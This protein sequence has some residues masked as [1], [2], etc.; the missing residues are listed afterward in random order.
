VNL[1]DTKAARW[2]APATGRWLLAV[3]VIFVCSS[4]FAADIPSLV[5]KAKP[6][7]VKLTC[8]DQDGKFLAGGTGFFISPDGKVLTNCHVIEDAYSIV[9]PVESFSPV[10]R[11]LGAHPR[12]PE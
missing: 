10:T 2:P 12:R 1:S 4:A 6:A 11:D 3:L 9:A 7:V 5:R 8:Y